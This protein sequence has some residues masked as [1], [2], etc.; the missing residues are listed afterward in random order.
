[1]ATLYPVAGCKLYIGGAVD[2]KSV[3]WVAADFTSQT[4]TEIKGWSQMGP[5]G[6]KAQLITTSLIGEN[7]DVKAKGTRN[8]GSMA[9]RFASDPTDAGQAALIAAERAKSNYAFRVVL[10]DAPVSGSAPTPSERLFIGLV[11]DAQEQGGEANAQRFL[12]ATI[13]VNSNIV[14]IEADTGD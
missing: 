10:N 6:D 1:M 3:D 7:R 5:L 8:A 13:E 12:E 2:R 4:W 14:R 11:M 9:N